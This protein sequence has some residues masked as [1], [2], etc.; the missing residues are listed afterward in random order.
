MNTIH[1]PWCGQRASANTLECRKCGGP[2][3]PPIG[4]DPGPAPPLP[5]RKLPAGYK[6]R[7]LFTNAPTTLVGSIFLM[8]GFPIGVVFTILGVALPGMWMFI[9]I[10]GGLGTIFTLLGGGMLYFGIHQGVSKIRPFEHGQATIG[11]V[12]DI[13]RD[14]SISV[15]GRNPWA[16]VY[17]FDAHGQ[18]FEGQ[19]I[20]WKHNPKTQE[21]GNR[22]YVLYMIDD[23]EQNVI[24]PPV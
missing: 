13:F 21:I 16:V 24:Y 18:T 9:A 20:T 12:V 5:P 11:E 23:P 1:C 14:Y 22:V 8:V 3:S 19:A 15:N 4:D 10:G 6:R 17:T 2:F 7:M